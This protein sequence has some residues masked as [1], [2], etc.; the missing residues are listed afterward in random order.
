MVLLCPT[1][2][3]PMHW[4]TPGFH[5]VHHLLEFAQI[6][7]HWVVMPSKHPTRYRPLLLLS[8]IFPSIK[9]FPVISSSVN[10]FSNLLSFLVPESFLMSPLFSSGGQSMGTSTSASIFPVNIQSWFHL[11]FTGLIS[12]QSKGLT[13]LLQHNSSKASILWHPAFFMVQLSHPYMSTG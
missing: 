1:L 2:S 8:S 5:V 9:V 10:P 12:L 11:G 3:N 13:S 7:V 6:Q 4:S